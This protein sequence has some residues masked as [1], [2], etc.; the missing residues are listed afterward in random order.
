MCVL[1][2]Q[3]T[4]SFKSCPNCVFKT[5]LRQIPF[6]TSRGLNWD[7]DTCKLKRSSLGLIYYVLNSKNFAKK[8]FWSVVQ[9]FSCP[10]L[11]VK[12]KNLTQC[13]LQMQTNSIQMQNNS[14]RSSG[15]RR[16][17]SSGLLVFPFVFA[18]NTFISPWS[19][20]HPTLGFFQFFSS[21]YNR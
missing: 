7:N 12:N 18:F 11:A 1:L 10:C 17:L 3:R 2:L 21:L 6:R 8:A 14:F 20:Y 16:M 9:P 4:F 19:C 15:L 5:D 13:H